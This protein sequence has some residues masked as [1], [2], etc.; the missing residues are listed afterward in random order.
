MMD[1]QGYRRQINA[2]GLGELK[3][4][5][6]SNQTD[7]KEVLRQ[8]RNFQ[9]SLRQ[10]KREINLEMKNIRANYREKTS[11]AGEGL[12]TVSML[13]GKKKLAGSIR[14]SA[15]RS[16]ASE[17]DQILA[18][19]EKLKLDIDALLTKLDSLKTQLE[20]YIQKEK[21]KEGKIEGSPISR[22][23]T[24]SQEEPK[25]FC[26]R[27]SCKIDPNDKFCRNCGQRLRFP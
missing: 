19:Y 26:P 3:K 2:L 20:N 21:T 25:T 8:V 16:M 18:P 13:F 4:V 27:C 10:I 12:S 6:I 11:T 22:K 17:R 24:E 5:K 14:A 7:A 23:A 15:K 9:K 1:S